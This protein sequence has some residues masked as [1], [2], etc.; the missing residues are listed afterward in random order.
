VSGERG[1]GVT[2]LVLAFDLIALRRVVARE[3]MVRRDAIYDSC[4][5]EP[6]QHSPSLVTVPEVM[7]IVLAAIVSALVTKAFDAS[8]VVVAV[9]TVGAVLAGIAWATLRA[10]QRVLGRVQDLEAAREGQRVDV[11]RIDKVLIGLNEKRKAD[12][13]GVE[14]RLRL[15]EAVAVPSWLPGVI[16][17]AQKEGWTVEFIGS[18]LQFNHAEREKEKVII[19]FPLGDEE[20]RY[21]DELFEHLAYKPYG[22]LLGEL[23]SGKRI[24]PGTRPRKVRRTSPGE[25]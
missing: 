20:N 21:R 8:W 4:V 14:R 15:V 10:F 19:S 6:S 12:V 5:A 17:H 11:Q 24:G 16:A 22:G 23:M 13:A 7:K 25:S 3:G 1:E 9:V 2:P 18:T